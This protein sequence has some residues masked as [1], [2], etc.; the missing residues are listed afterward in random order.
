MRLLLFRI[1]ALVLALIS[2]A[3]HGKGSKMASMEEL[4]EQAEHWLL[5]YDDDENGHLSADEIQGVMQEMR[6]RSAMENSVSQEQQNMLTPE[7][8]L[9]M[10]DADGDGA[11][12]KPELVDWLKRMKGYDGGHLQRG[13]ASKP[14][15]GSEAS[16]LG[17]DTHMERMRKKKRKKATKSAVKD[18]P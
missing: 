3:V 16:K 1:L 7:L 6:E 15:A 4:V 17:G 14:A 10:T 5:D 2:K 12:S 8:L 13:E 11:A 18:E 9:Q